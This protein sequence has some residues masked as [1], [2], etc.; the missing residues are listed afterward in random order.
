M[1]SSRFANF[2]MLTTMSFPI[3]ENSL[4]SFYGRFSSDSESGT[5]YC[6]KLKLMNKTSAFK[7]RKNLPV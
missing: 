2:F 1:K 3:E 5:Q 4:N 7:S 6:L